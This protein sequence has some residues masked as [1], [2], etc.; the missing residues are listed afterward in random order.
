[1]NDQNLKTELLRF[2]WVGLGSNAINFAVY[3]LVVKLGQALFMSSLMGYMV[4]LTFS[5]Y[6]GQSWVFKSERQ[7]SPTIVLKFLAVY[8]VGGIGMSAIIDVTH[9]ITLL[10]YRLCWLI[11]AVFAVINNFLGS[12]FLVFRQQGLNQ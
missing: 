8:L 2:L 3:Y 11:G 5:I 7:S 6:L 1:M 12:K 4:G 10:D 9:Q